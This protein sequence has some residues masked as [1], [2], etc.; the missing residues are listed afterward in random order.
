M[1]IN[2]S[3]LAPNRV[4]F[5]PISKVGLKTGQVEGLAEAR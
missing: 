4:A 1:T 2:Q 5:K 3:F